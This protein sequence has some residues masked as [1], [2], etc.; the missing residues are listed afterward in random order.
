MVQIVG[1]GMVFNCGREKLVSEI[2]RN[3]YQYF[4]QFADDHPIGTTLTYTSIDTDTQY[5]ITV[6]EPIN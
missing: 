1:A 2:L 3:D 6:I 4:K 5:K